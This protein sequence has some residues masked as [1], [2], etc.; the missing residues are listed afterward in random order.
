MNSIIGKVAVLAGD[1]IGPELMQETLKVLAAMQQ[2]YGFAVE[3]HIGL[4]GGA[5]IDVVG[6]ALP[7]ETLRLC[8]AADA[9][10]FGSVGGPK[11]TTLAPERQPETAA[12]LALRKHFDLFC[13]LR[14]AKIYSCLAPM[15]PLKSSI[16]AAGVDILCV[17]ELTSG[18]YFGVPRF[19]RGVGDEEMA[20]DSM[21]YSRSEIKRIARIA[22][23]LARGRSRRLASIDKANVLASMQLWRQVVDEVHRDFPDVAVE[24]LYVDNAAMQVMRRPADF[25]V[26]LC[27]NL[28][29]DI[30]SDQ[31][32]MIT[33][34]LGLLP[35]AAINGSGFG[36]YEPSGGSAPDI[37]GQGIANP[38]A[39]ILSLGLLLRH[40][41]LRPDLDNALQNAVARTLAS[42]A[43][44][45]DIYTGDSDQQ[46]LGTQAFVEAV[47][48][49]LPPRSRTKLPQEVP[50]A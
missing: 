28:F 24:H 32:A 17:R 25:D 1:G 40:S 27:P 2:R 9:I 35:S 18:I 46:E 23:D 13:N 47:I 38:V 11:W 30:L 41:L 48:D 45:R 7:D 37:A 34:S 15:S 44:T 20:L 26:M 49:H 8:E 12:L 4:V 50:H 5:A 43:R 31:I 39:Q 42:G 19:R 6:E 21:S 3:C 16:V 10:L 22:F 29:G 33:G 14:P 36:L